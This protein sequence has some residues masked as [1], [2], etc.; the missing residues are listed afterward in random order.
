MRFKKNKCRLINRMK[1]NPFLQV[2]QKGSDS[3]RPKQGTRPE[4]V[5]LSV[6]LDAKKFQGKRR[7][8]KYVAMTRDEGNALDGPFSAIC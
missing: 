1:K 5:G 2:A 3:R 4:G 6:A 8:Y 7:T